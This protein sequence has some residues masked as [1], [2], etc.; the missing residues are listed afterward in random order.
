MKSLL[1]LALLCA[2]CGSIDNYRIMTGVARVQHA[3]EIQVAMEEEPRPPSFTEI[4]LLTASGY[5]IYSTEGDVL[6]AL[7]TQAA[8]LGADAV[9]RIHFDRGGNAVFGTGVAVL[10]NGGPV[11]GEDTP[12]PSQPSAAPPSTVPA[13][14]PGYENAIPAPPAGLPQ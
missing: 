8:K 1:V 6:E 11:R 10:L 12:Q 13:V 7:R 2:G 3:G 9:V 14:P 5:G 4:A